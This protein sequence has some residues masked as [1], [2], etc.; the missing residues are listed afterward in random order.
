[1]GRAGAQCIP[2]P[3]QPKLMPTGRC[4]DPVRVT[5][6]HLVY[7]LSSGLGF[8]TGFPEGTSS[9]IHHP[10]RQPPV[11]RA[12]TTGRGWNPVS[13]H[14][15]PGNLATPW[16]GGSGASVLS[17]LL[18][19]HP[20]GPQGG[21]SPQTGAQPV[22]L[23][24][25]HLGGPVPSAAPPGG[26]GGCR[27]RTRLRAGTAAEI[28]RSARF[29]NWFKLSAMQAFPEEGAVRRIPKNSERTGTAPSL[30]PKWHICH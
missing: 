7:R 11:Y 27:D 21:G 28:W 6:G 18:P 29:K 13:C 25:A 23:E 4:P 20:R 19:T 1:M 24:W 22:L 15:T 5:R 8:P 10:T 16:G 17:L 30:E 9:A 3:L 12:P 14:G 2:Y 26:G